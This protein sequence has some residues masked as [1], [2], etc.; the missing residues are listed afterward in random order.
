MGIT[1]AV[2]LRYDPRVARGGVDLAWAADAGAPRR[3]TREEAAAFCGLVA[4]WNVVGPVVADDGALL[5]AHAEPV[6]LDPDVVRHLP[7]WLTAVVARHAAEDAR[8]EAP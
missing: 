2:S 8:R 1:L 5:V 6:P 7:P 4:A 3:M